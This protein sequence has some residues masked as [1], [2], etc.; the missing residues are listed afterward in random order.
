MANVNYLDKY[1]AEGNDPVE[2]FKDAEKFCKFIEMELKQ[3][4]L[5]GKKKINR[6][7]SESG[8]RI[9]RSQKE[10]VNNTRRRQNE[11]N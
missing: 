11:R 4:I 6:P 1:L 3:E 10:W 2:T 8:Y 9:A 5:R 7:Y